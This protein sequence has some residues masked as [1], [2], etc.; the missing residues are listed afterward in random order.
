MVR[1]R[2]VSGERGTTLIHPADFD[3]Q[4]ECAMDPS[5]LLREFLEGKVSRRDFC[6]I[7]A[8]AAFLVAFVN[9]CNFQTP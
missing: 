1:E 6:K 3:G 4:G 8:I 5:E 2:W 7:G 9:W